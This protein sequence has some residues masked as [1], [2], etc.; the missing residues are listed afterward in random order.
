MQGIVKFFQDQ[1]KAAA[2]HSAKVGWLSARKSYE[3][4]GEGGQQVALVGVVRYL[5]ACKRMQVEV[6]HEAVTEIIRDAKDERAVWLEQDFKTGLSPLE[7]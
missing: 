1:E 4:L 2:E 6:T 3:R 5:K 7:L